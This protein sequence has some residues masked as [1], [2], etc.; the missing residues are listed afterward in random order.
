MWIMT[1]LEEN[2]FQRKSLAAV[3]AGFRKELI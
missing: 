3:E 2:A 1:S